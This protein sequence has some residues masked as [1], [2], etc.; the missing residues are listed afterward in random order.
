M[1]FLISRSSPRALILCAAIFV[2]SATL[3]NAGVIRGTVTDASGATVTGATIVLMNGVS[4]VNKTV[5]TADGSYQFVT[6]QSGRFSLI[7]TAQSFRQLEVPAFYAGA[8]DSVER[9]LV[10][11]PEWVHQSIVVS[12]T[13]TPLPQQQTSFETDLFSTLD[14]ARREDFVSVLRME[15]GAVV[16]Q[17][18]QRGAQTSLFLRGGDSNAARILF[19]GA[20]VDEIGGL[21]DLGSLSTTGVQSAEVYR[22]PNSSLYGSDAASGVVNF[23]TNRGVSSSPVVTF[24]GDLGNFHTAR[25]QLEL[26][27]S[28]KQL[29]YYGGYSWLQSENSIPMDRYHLGT[30]AGNFGWQQS[31]NLQIRGALR[32]GVSAVGVPNAWDFYRI[33]D[34]RKQSDQ[35]LYMS[36]SVDYQFTPDF[37]NQVRYGGARKREQSMQWYAAGICIPAGSCDEPEGTAGAGNWYGEDVTI[38]GANGAQVVGQAILDYSTANYSVYPNRLDLVTNRDQILYEGDFHFTPHL[39]ALVGFH[40]ENER[41]AEREP[42]YFL[43]DVVQRDNYDYLAE[44]HGDFKGRLFYTLGGSLEHYQIIG[45][46]TSPRA[47]LSFYVVKP[48]RGFFN[49]TRLNGNFSDAVREP[50]LADQSGS[51]YSFL[52]AQPGGPAT[53]QQLHIPQLEAPTARTWEGGLE[54]GLL[55]EH[56]VFHLNLFH[57]EFGRQIENVGVGLIPELLPGL[58]TAQQQALEA[59]LNNNGAYS[60]DV[61]S[62]AFRA[63]GIESTVEAGLGR[64]IFLKGGYTYLDTVVQRSFSSDNQ[65]LLGGYAPTYEGVPIGIYSPLVG[66]RPFR[67]PPHTGFVTGSYAGKKWTVSSTAAFSSRSDDS[68]FLGYMDINQGNSLLL[69]N[70]NLDYGFAK[71]DFGGS[72]QLFSRLAIYGQ[73]ENLTSN[74]HIAPIGYPSLPFNFR[75]G[76]RIWVGKKTAE[77]NSNPN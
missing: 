14:L 66:A 7:I 29:D 71:I 40:Y 58:T 56:I 8:G 9:N 61:N 72:F 19:D 5:S 6:G 26:A 10:L 1:S 23:T 16:V 48:R 20:T 73:A 65:A 42:V 67:R 63:M 43:N 44:V 69:P 76:L 36:G 15:P 21:F 77:A 11:E 45:T 39:T 51:L 35:N 31:A 12:A 13:G 59:F 57:N 22:G 60:L 27:G 53:I 33:A 17:A 34:D 50:T 32:Y 3:L 18:G 47:G 30:A 54:Q 24:N 62:E 64:S 28:R 49:G 74:Q 25:N 70:R 52:Q 75:M 55:G 37:H 2:L 68:T 46:Q 41:G 4:Y 38:R